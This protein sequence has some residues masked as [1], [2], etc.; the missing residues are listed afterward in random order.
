M[1]FV[2]RFVMMVVGKVS[3]AMRMYGVSCVFD[4]GILSPPVL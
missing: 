3:V 4:A 1:R 2:A